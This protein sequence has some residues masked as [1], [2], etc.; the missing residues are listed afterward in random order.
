M[1]SYMSY[2]TG[3]LRRLAPRIPTE[4]LCSELVADREQ[5]ALIVDVSE[6]GLRM[7][8]PLG[9]RRDGRVVRLEFELP[10]VDEIIWAKGE[11]CF[12]QMWRASVAPSGAVWT[13]GVRVVAA[14]QKHLRLMRD[15]V[16]E[17]RRQIALV[18]QP[19]SERFNLG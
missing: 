12:D 15:W 1:M 10:G 11:I 13:T 18:E 14:A 2:S 16:H 8:R 7:Q 5:Y 17:Q 6:E 4:T 3:L 19:W 9:R